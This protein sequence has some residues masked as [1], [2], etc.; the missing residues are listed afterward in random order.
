MRAAT[1]SLLLLLAAGP[2]PALADDCSVAGAGISFGRIDP[3]TPESLQ[4]VGQLTVQCTGSVTQLRLRVQSA[5][6]TPGGQRQLASG[7]HRLRYRLYQ[8]ESHQI[9]LG[10]D[11]PGSPAMT[12]MLAPG[13]VVLV[14][15]YAVIE[16]GQL[17]A[18]GQYSD[19]MVL[20][21]DF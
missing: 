1:L 5:Y 9:P 3:F 19:H 18:P 4:P 20:S 15:L 10:D 17:P 13:A 7:P 8:D 2:G 14:P 16:P 21:I 6:A 11:T 12:V